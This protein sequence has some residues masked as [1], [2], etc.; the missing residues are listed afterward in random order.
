M[1]SPGGK[2]GSASSLPPGEL[3]VRAAWLLSAIAVALF[4]VIP[5]TIVSGLMGA[6][7]GWLAGLKR[8]P[9][10]GRLLRV[11]LGATAVGL[12]LGLLWHFVVKSG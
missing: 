4:P 12:V 9:Q 10:G 11:G 1:S 7:F 3:E 2:A 5:A 6:T 8:H